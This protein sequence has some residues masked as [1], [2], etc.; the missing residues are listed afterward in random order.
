MTFLQTV[1]KWKRERERESH[2]P[3][4]NPKLQKSLIK[5]SPFISYFNPCESYLATHFFLFPFFPLFDFPFSSIPSSP[6]FLINSFHLPLILHSKFP[7]STRKNKCLRK[8]FTMLLYTLVLLLES[9]WLGLSM[10][11]WAPLLEGALE[12]KEMLTN[13]LRVLSFL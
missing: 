12:G 11:A 6:Q 8:R 4:K 10:K 1:N 2:K 5:F 9:F 3:N 13:L 7:S